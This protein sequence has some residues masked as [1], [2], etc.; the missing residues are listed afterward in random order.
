M[1]AL[2][3]GA[4]VQKQSEKDLWRLLNAIVSQTWNNIV[5]PTLLQEHIK[6]C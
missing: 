2:G 5:I 4:T 6:N 1:N 3:K